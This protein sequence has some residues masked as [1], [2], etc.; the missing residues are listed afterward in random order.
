MTTPRRRALIVDGDEAHLAFAAEALSSFR[1][2]FDVATARDL[3]QAA[4]WLDT[5]PPDLL[6]LDLDLP[7]DAA[8]RFTHQ[9]R[10]DPR[11]RNCKILG[12]GTE[13]PA[14]GRAEAVLPRPLRLQTLL[15]AVQKL[16]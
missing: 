7:G 8:D 14:A 5:F 15:T 11:T 10:A 9:L 16:I 12:I 3:G 6:L 4:E 1:P 2:G 13:R